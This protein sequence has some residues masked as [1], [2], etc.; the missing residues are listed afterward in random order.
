MSEYKLCYVDLDTVLFR[1]A[2]SCQEDYIIVKHKETGEEFEFS[3]VQK[4][5]GTK[6][7]TKDGGWIGDQNKKRL[8]K[9]LEPYKF[10]MFTI[11]EHARLVGSPEEVIKNALEQIDYSV[12]RIKKHSQAED[13]KLCIGGEGNWRY[14]YATIL[15][16]KGQ[17][18]AK[19]L[20]FLEVKEAF[21][22]KYKKKVIIVDKME[23]DDYL[24]IIGF[25]NYQNFV[26]TKEW[27]YVLSF[28]DKDLKM[29]LSPHFNYDKPE[30]GISVTTPVDS[31]RHF[32]SQILSGDKTTD[33]ILGLPSLTRDI[34]D[35]YNLRKCK[36][37]GKDTAYKLVNNLSI[38]EC[39]ELVIE[40][41]KA[42]YG[43]AK[44]EF[45]DFRGTHHLYNWLDYL[46]ENA[47]LLWM[48]RFEDEEYNIEDT[49][50][51]LKIEY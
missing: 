49:F 14:D 48:M 32:C 1:S 40:C 31:A 3:G 29:I 50:K 34:Q 17:R 45:I 21:I 10:D 39:F 36:G 44:K 28:I 43:E 33:N 22:K 4:F 9:G 47:R 37:I 12:G 46:K 26:K 18:K 25:K 11:T 24:G 5:Y 30:D 19:P 13:Y 41:Y 8:E 42:Y 6:P 16:Y 51:R 15:P 35:K 7:S 23:V 38:K 27:L 2:K 20:M